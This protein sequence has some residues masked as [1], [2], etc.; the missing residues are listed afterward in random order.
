LAGTHH[1]GSDKSLEH[2]A[3]ITGARPNG[4]RVNGAYLRPAADNVA[5]SRNNPDKIET[6]AATSQERNST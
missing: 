3:A 6:S 1:D 2:L 5:A 4:H